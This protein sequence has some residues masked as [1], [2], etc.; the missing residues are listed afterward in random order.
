MR[1]TEFKKVQD[2]APENVSVVQEGT[3]I[4]ITKKCFSPNSGEALEDEVTRERLEHMENEF[5]NAQR[6]KD[7]AEDVINAYNAIINEL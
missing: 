4:V 5:E 6:E 1:W 3:E 2:E 7:R